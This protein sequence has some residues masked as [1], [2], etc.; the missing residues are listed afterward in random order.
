M[1]VHRLGRGRRGEGYDHRPVVPNGDFDRCR[2]WRRAKTA[3]GELNIEPG[4]QN[5]IK[6]R[7]GTAQ[8]DKTPKVV[9]TPFRPHHPFLKFKVPLLILWSIRALVQKDERLACLTRP[10]ALRHDASI[11]EAKD[12]VE[13][14]AAQEVRQINKGRIE[15]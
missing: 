11:E 3:H 4:S 8:I 1:P 9:G 5:A 7:I 6:R 10:R 12:S 13:A 2:L 14:Q 15:A